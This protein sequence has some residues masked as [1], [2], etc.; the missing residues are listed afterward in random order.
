MKN[1]NIILLDIIFFVFREIRMQDDNIK[2]QVNTLKT[3]IEKLEKKLEVQKDQHKEDEIN[4]I[5]AHCIE[6]LSPLRN[7]NV[8]LLRYFKSIIVLYCIKVLKRYS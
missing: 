1:L 4:E 8:Q 3:D 2:K 7:L 5:H 6:R